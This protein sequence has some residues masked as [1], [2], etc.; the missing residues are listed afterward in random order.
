METAVLVAQALA[1]GLIAAWLSLG[2]RDNLLYPSVNETYTAQVLAMTR[3]QADYPEEFQQVAHRAITDRRLQSLAFKLVV[4]AESVAC[5]M[6]WIGTIGL[7]MALAGTA[8]PETGRMLALLGALSFTTVWATFLI[9]G[10]HFCYWFC[11]EGAQN[12]HFQMTL[13]GLAT[14]VLLCQG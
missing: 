4:L 6:L 3:M 7:L 2:L 9:V 1:T 10:N 14:M 8:L 12:T 11:H 5:L 13:W